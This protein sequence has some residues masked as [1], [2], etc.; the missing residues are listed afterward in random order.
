MEAKDRPALD[1]ADLDRLN[2]LLARALSDYEDE[3]NSVCADEFA[4]VIVRRLDVEGYE[5]RRRSVA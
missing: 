3:Q 4:M 2:S 1:E 5:V